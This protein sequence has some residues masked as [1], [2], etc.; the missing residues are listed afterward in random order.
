[1]QKQNIVI[2]FSTK[3][4][5]SEIKSFGSNLPKQ[6]KRH[7]KKVKFSIKK[8]SILSQHCHNNS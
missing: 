4:H 3:S 2:I 7:S 1:M 5:L 8:G 6:I